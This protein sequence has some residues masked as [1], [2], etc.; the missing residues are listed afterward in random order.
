MLSLR[1]RLF[2]SYLL[3]LSVTL[4]AIAVALLVIVNTRPAP[5]QQTYQRLAAIAQGV[6]LREILTEASAGI[7]TTPRE[8]LQIVEAELTRLAEDRNVRILIVNARNNA[9]IY[10]S[11]STVTPGQLLNVQL[12]PYTIP[13]PIRR[14]FSPRV[15]TVF[16]NFVDPTS[17]EWLFVGLTTTDPAGAAS[18]A[19]LFADPHETQSLQQA[20]AEFSSALALPLCQSALVGLVVA[21]ILAIWGSRTIARPLQTVA[22]AATNVAEGHYNE[23]VPISG[24]PE[25][26]ALGEAF[27]YM[28]SQ[29]QGTQRAQQD[30]LAN[31]S[32]DLKT[33][34]TSIQGYSQAIMDGAASDPVQAASIIHEEAGR[35]NRM[36]TEL[37]DLARLQAGQLSMRSGAL[38]IGQITAAVGQRLAIVAREKGVRLEVDATPMPDIAGDGDRMAQVL[39]NLISN[40]IKYTPQGGSV[41]VQTLMANGGVEVVV[42][43]TGIGIPPEELPRV[44]ERFYQVDKARGPERGTGL[45][46]AIVREIVQA[47]GGRINVAS[48][49]TGKGTTF[50]LWLPSPLLTTLVR[51]RR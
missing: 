20:L 40:A 23:R 46:L 49:G 41:Y 11:A 30:F 2:A 27:N 35:M 22:K 3:L 10:D 14:G 45:G 28:T 16:G 48:A 31:V 39:T 51:S 15:E 37:T 44:F 34:L 12:D 18:G 21:S 29:V 6:P 32:H 24:P 19:L 9:V 50:T 38:D 43:D 1:S 4:G 7:F 13:A 5:P 25:V 8:R 42:R 26:Q 17:G 47:H 33:P 36:V